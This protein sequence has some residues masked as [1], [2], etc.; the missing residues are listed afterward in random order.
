[1][2]HSRRAIVYFWFSIQ[3]FASTYLFCSDLETRS[4][5]VGRYDTRDKLNA[6]MDRQCA[7]ALKKKAA[8]SPRAAVTA[9]SHTTAL[10]HDSPSH[11]GTGHQ[12]AK[13]GDKPLPKKP[14]VRMDWML[15]P[16]AST[17]S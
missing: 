5:D 16:P 3:S 12:L 4:R 1:M 11:G 13:D 8:A 10:A 15:P 14:R 9:P 7:K 17:S 2:R 6:W